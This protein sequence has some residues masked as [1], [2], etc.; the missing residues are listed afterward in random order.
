TWSTLAP[1]Q[2]G[3][4]PIYFA[5]AVLPDGR[6]IVEG[7]E[8]NCNSTGG[9]CMSVWQTLGAIYN[10]TTNT[11]ATVTPPSG[12]TTIGDASGIVLAD[13]TFFLSDCCT[14]KTAKLN[15]T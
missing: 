11:W 7:G 5:S 15:A 10:P 13:G 1:M 12:W 9:S 3:F 8:Y 14:K 2:A 4:N 6:V